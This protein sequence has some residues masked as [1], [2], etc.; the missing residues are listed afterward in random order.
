MYFATSSRSLVFELSRTAQ[1]VPRPP[2]SLPPPRSALTGSAISSRETARYRALHQPAIPQEPSLQG[3]SEVA[4][5]S[6]DHM[7]HGQVH[8]R[9]PPERDRD[10]VLS[11]A[12]SK[13]PFFSKA[14]QRCR[15]SRPVP[16]RTRS[17]LRKGFVVRA[18][19]RS[20]QGFITPRSTT[21]RRRNST[22]T[23]SWGWSR[24]CVPRQVML[25]F[26][27]TYFFGGSCGK[28]SRRA[29]A[30][31]SDSALIRQMCGLC[32]IIRFVQYFLGPTKALRLT[33]SFQD[34]CTFAHYVLDQKISL[35]VLSLE[36]ARD[37][38][39]RVW[40]CGT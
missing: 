3:H 31:L 36:I 40:P 38:L 17:G 13:Q 39:S 22:R 11:V 25:P 19:A 30:Q 35:M 27:H 7:G 33:T 18:V 15:C 37:V 32:C 23:G 26:S 14:G 8:T 4:E 12:C 16:R 34:A 20:Q 21:R 24:S 29:F 28:N 1:V 9:P 5:K 6:E 10:R 2:L